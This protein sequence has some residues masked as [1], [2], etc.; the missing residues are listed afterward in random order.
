MKSHRM[1]GSMSSPSLGLAPVTLTWVYWLAYS[2]CRPL[3]AGRFRV[4]MYTVRVL[5]GSTA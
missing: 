2:A 4:W 1:L 3:A 5:S